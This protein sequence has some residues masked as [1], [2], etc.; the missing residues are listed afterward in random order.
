MVAQLESFD[1]VDA[2]GQTQEQTDFRDHSP[3]GTGT[4]MPMRPTSMIRP[5]TTVSQSMASLWF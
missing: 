2:Q 1:Q 4:T 5:T 3:G